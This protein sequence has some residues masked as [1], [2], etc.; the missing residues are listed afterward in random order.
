MSHDDLGEFLE[1][2]GA[3]VDGS[4]FHA[5]AAPWGEYALEVI[6]A[7]PGTP[8]AYCEAHVAFPAGAEHALIG[9]RG[10][11]GGTGG[12][13]SFARCPDDAGWLEVGRTRVDLLDEDASFYT[14]GARRALIYP[15][16]PSRV[17]ARDLIRHA[18]HPRLR[19]CSSSCCYEA[20]DAFRAELTSSMARHRTLTSLI[21]ERP[22]PH[23]FG[24]GPQGPRSDESPNPR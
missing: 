12:S 2:S 10:I 5:V 1:G 16:C 13:A 8:A 3:D 17:N 20:S 7:R 19:L 23:V 21:A 11:V 22:D 4:L 15:S 9:I 14:A 18:R 6:S 24:S